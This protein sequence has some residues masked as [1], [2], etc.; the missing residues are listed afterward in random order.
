MDRA[1]R[2]GLGKLIL[3]PLELDAFSLIFSHPQTYKRKGVKADCTPRK[4]G[5]Y[6]AHLLS[7][8]VVIPGWC[9]KGLDPWYKALEKLDVIQ[10][11]EP[12]GS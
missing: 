6:C 7:I 10:Q 5:D 4:Q 2:P 1:Q 12:Q 3:A 11:R 8:A 9:N